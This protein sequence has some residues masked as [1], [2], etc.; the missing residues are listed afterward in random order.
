[1]AAAQMQLI[2][3]KAVEFR[4]NIVSEVKTSLIIIVV[5]FYFKRAPKL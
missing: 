4:S 1:M 2:I 3:L 5:R